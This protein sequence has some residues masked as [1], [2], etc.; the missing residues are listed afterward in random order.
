V[1][2]ADDHTILRDGL[3][4]LLEQEPDFE[5]IGEAGNGLEAVRRVRT[6]RPDVVLLDIA[7]P[8][9][10]GVEAARQILSTAP[11]TKIVVLSMHADARYVREMLAIGAVGYLLKQSAF[12]EIVE[13]TR[14][15]A[16]NQAYFSPAVAGIVAEQFRTDAIRITQDTSPLTPREKQVLQLLAEGNS[17]RVVAEKLHISVKT[18]ETHRRRL[19]AKIDIHNLAG[20]TKYAVRVG[21]TG[22]DI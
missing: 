2:L 6:L 3:R 20:L 8:D 13:A 10:N 22:I 4:K 7:M 1:V 17:P 5:V 19:M 9:L 14:A 18:V 12:E 15:V 16:R 21:L 11:G